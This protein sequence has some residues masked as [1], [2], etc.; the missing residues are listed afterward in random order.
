MNNFTLSAC[1]LICGA[2]KFLVKMENNNYDRVKYNA[3]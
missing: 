2:F 3:I 1:I